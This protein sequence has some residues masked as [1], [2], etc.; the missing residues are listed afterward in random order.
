MS[1]RSGKTQTS[2]KKEEK[3]LSKK[4]EKKRKQDNKKMESKQ[5]K[6]DTGTSGQISELKKR[7]GVKKFKEYR[8]YGNI[9]PSPALPDPVLEGRRQH[10]CRQAGHRVER[11][12][13]SAPGG[14]CQDTARQ[15]L[16]RGVISDRAVEPSTTLKN[17]A[18]LTAVDGTE[19]GQGK[20]GMI[21]LL[22]G[23]ATMT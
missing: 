10:V 14:L 17:D 12:E 3:R 23:L 16:H 7:G 19:V 18:W 4:L 6:N 8:T 13:C 15:A 20:S 21:H 2:I 11:P 22:K 9:R 5:E 1:D